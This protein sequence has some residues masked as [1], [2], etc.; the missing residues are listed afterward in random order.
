MNKR[1]SENFGLFGSYNE[2][3]PAEP[4]GTDGPAQQNNTAKKEGI[5]IT[6]EKKEINKSTRKMVKKAKTESVAAAIEENANKLDIFGSEKKTETKKK[7]KYNLRDRADSSDAQSD[8]EPS[9][10][11]LKE[12]EICK[13][14]PKKWS[15]KR[16]LKG[17]DEKKKKL[18]PETP[19]KVEKKPKTMLMPCMSHK[20]NDDA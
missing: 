4:A 7:A 6:S 8:S 19:K 18:K 5:L 12:D 14:I 1:T 3:K 11:N 13:L 16:Y 15:K 2:D 9:E 10:D 17:I 20:K